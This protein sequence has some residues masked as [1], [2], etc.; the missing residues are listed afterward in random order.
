MRSLLDIILKARSSVRRRGLPAQDVDD[1][2]QEAFARL[3]AY[4]RAHEIRSQ[5]A[6]VV[7]AAGNIIRDEARRRRT[8]PFDDAPLDLESLIDTAPQPEQV[9]RGQERLRRAVA[10]LNQL[11]PRA[12]TMLLAH[13]LDGLTI[14]QIAAREGTSVAATQK[15]IAR[16][17]LFLIKWMDGW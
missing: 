2:V 7:H 11:N 3:E 12:R 4:A 13:R 9:A 15:Q 1:V 17:A 6:F 5:E 8:S 14:P 10:G 16:A